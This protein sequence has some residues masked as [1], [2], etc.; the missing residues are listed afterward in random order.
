LKES[1][2]WEKKFDD[3]INAQQSLY[4]ECVA[5]DDVEDDKNVVSEKITALTDAITSKV[6]SLN[7]EILEFKTETKPDRLGKHFNADVME[8]SSQKILV[9]CENF[10]SFT[11]TLIIKN[12]TKAALRDAL[13]V[14]T[15]I[16]SHY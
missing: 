1:K 14:L 16:P 15:S 7:L 8:E 4:E 2:G 12:Q 10:T 13:I 11:D 3:I 6:S 5:L 9:F